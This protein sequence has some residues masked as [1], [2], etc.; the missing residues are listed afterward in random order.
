MMSLQEEAMIYPAEEAM[1]AWIDDTNLRKRKIQKHRWAHLNGK[2]SK[3][4]KNWHHIYFD[5]CN[6]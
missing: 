2:T 1:T 3:L 4:M 5:R 6:Y